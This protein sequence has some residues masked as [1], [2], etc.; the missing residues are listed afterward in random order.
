MHGYANPMWYYQLFSCLFEGKKST[1]LPP[2]FS[3]DIVENF[4]VY[5]HAKNKLHHS[6]HSWDITF[7]RILQFDWLT[8]FWPITWEPEF[9]QIWNRWWNINNNIS[10]HFRL[11]PRKTNDRFFQKIQKILFRGH[12]WHFLPK[13]GQ[14]NFFLEKR[15]LSVFRYSN[16]LPLCQK[17]EKNNWAISEEN[18]ELM[19][20]RTDR[21][22]WFYRTLHRTGSKNSTTVSES[23]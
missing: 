15:A 7:Q 8:A 20:G 22:R 13:F 10:F 18:A 23:M 3:E 1:S 21:Q 9:C 14:E 19:D 16:S 5:L 12:F 17:S 11:F 4:D 6:L 2:C